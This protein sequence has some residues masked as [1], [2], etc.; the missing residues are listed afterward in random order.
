MTGFKDK[1]GKEIKEGDKIKIP[2]W[3]GTITEAPDILVEAVVK[4]GMYRCDI[5]SWP[6]EDNRGELL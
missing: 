5:G 2:L 3:A 4:N 1:N 6:L